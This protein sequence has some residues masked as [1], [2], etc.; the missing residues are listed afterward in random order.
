MHPGCTAIIAISVGLHTYRPTY[1]PTY[2]DTFYQP[3]T[4]KRGPIQTYCL[5]LSICVLPSIQLAVS[6]K[7]VA[8]VGA[9]I[10][11][12]TAY[13]HANMHTCTYMHA[14]LHTCLPLA[15][16]HAGMHTSIQTCLFFKRMSEINVITQVPRL[17]FTQQVLAKSWQGGRGQRDFWDNSQIS[18][19]RD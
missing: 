10:H 7:K 8:L 2:L 19:P 5:L 12:Y 11:H 14:C 1:L 3:S 15:E 18:F 16:T 9:Y 13:T 6:T 4:Y 17:P